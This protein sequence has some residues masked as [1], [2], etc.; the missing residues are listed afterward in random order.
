MLAHLVAE[1]LDLA[2]RSVDG[3]IAAVVIAVRV[4]LN[5]QRK[6]FHTLLGGEICT[7]A[8][9]GDEDLKEGEKL[10]SSQPPYR[11]LPRRDVGRHTKSKPLKDL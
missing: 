6:S 10:V 3:F 4:D 8:V 5:H 11:Q 7:Q 9:H 1:D 2:V